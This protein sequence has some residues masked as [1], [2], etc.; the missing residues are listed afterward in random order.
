MLTVEKD[1]KPPSLLAQVA[2]LGL[3][4]EGSRWK[5]LKF[6][7]TSCGLIKINDPR[8]VSILH[9][10][11]VYISSRGPF[12]Q[13][14]GCS[15]SVVVETPLTRTPRCGD[16]RGHRRARPGP[17]DVSA[18][19]TIQSGTHGGVAC[20][21]IFRID[22]ARSRPVT[23]ARIALPTEARSEAQS[24]CSA[25]A[26]APSGQL[27]RAALCALV[28]ECAAVVREAEQ[29]DAAVGRAGSRWVPTGIRRRLRW[30]S[31]RDSR[32]SASQS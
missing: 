16:G 13:R 22:S 11:V 17:T 6:L 28:G 9:V 24:A 12:D 2:R 3:I 31:R 26:L 25:G 21:A 4:A 14:L 18:C 1:L 32:H 30:R 5:T 27:P 29:W 10:D 19:W 23:G 7:R 8:D 20:P 15:P